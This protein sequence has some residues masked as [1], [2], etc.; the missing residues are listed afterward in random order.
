MDADPDLPPEPET[1]HISAAPEDYASPITL[2]QVVWP[3]VWLVAA[4][5]L[6]LIVRQ[7]GWPPFGGGH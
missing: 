6:L 5:G 3:T 7:L 1:R 4:V 2:R